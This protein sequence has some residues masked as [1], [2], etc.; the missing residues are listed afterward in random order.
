MFLLPVVIILLLNQFLRKNYL[1]DKQ[2]ERSTKKEMK[3][4]LIVTFGVSTL[5]Q[6]ALSNQT[7]SMKVIHES[8]PWKSY[9]TVIH[10]SHIWQSSMKVIYESHPW[11]SSMT[12]HVSQIA[13]VSFN[14]SFSVSCGGH[15]AYH[16][17]LCPIDVREGYYYG[18]SYCGGDCRWEENG[19]NSSCVSRRKETAGLHSYH[20]CYHPPPPTIFKNGKRGW[21][22]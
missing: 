22:S 5:V 10:E 21:F 18:K 6:N 13:T 2:G 9:M 12:V 4:G 14:Y 16:C 1:K 11:K 20:Y 17:F 15:L 3:P 19:L 7:S 8:H